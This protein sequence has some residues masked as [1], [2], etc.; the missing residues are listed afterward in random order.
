MGTPRQEFTVGVLALQGAF[1]EHIRALEAVGS[2]KTREVRLPEQLTEDLDGLVIPGGESTAM[3]I[4]G[5]RYGIF[6]K[7]RE[8]VSSGKPVWG[9]CAGM[10]LLSDKAIM[11][12]EGGQPLIGGLDVDVCRNYFGSQVSS[13][14]VPLQLEGAAST[15]F[16]GAAFSAVFIRAPAILKAGKDVEVLARVRADPCPAAKKPVEDF[17]AAQKEDGGPNKRQK[18][19]A[20]P[21]TP[22]GTI[23]AAEGDETR[24]VIVA[25]RQGNILAT[26]F[27]PELT[28][29]RSWHRFF[30]GIV[31]EAVSGSK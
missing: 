2:V 14:E 19:Q 6:P 27:H 30:M 17:D 16:P 22:D 10:I 18:V 15:A 21:G 8:F 26:A 5:E 13:F 1:R 7:L 3:A 11:Q 23:A 12:K 28:E 31:S 29:D 20:P 25:A 4:V 24:E 9:T